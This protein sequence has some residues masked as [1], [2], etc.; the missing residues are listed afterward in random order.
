MLH[1]EAELHEVVEHL[2][3][4]RAR[5]SSCGFRVSSCRL[6]LG[7]AA[8]GTGELTK[9]TCCS[10]S[11][12]PLRSLRSTWSSPP[13]QK[14]MTMCSVPLS[15]NES[16]YRTMFGWLNAASSLISF[17]ASSCSFGFMRDTSTCLMTYCL[18]EPRALTR[19]AAPN[20]PLPT[21]LTFW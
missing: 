11:T 18:P 14:S 17:F 20:A 2:V 8:H 7:L 9:S 16:R 6:G 10:E 21:T 15:M 13:S 5:L 1:G 4:V 12:A 3:R 19:T